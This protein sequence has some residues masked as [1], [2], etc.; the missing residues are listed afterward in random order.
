MMKAGSNLPFKTVEIK[1]VQL[2]TSVN[3]PWLGVSVTPASMG[4][5]TGVQTLVIQFSL[6]PRY[7]LSSSSHCSRYDSEG[8]YL[9]SLP[10]LA[11]PRT[12]HGCTSFVSKQGEQVKLIF[13]LYLKNRACLLL[14]V[15]AASSS[16]CP[17]LS[18]SS[19]QTEDG[20]QE[21]TF[22]GENYFQISALCVLQ[23]RVNFPQ[24][25]GRS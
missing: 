22:Q 7:D 24:R 16:T 21:E 1:P 2:P 23:C 10:D 6:W 9:G 11:T 14:E 17:A 15:Q 8:K 12:N 4:R 5:W 25:Y 13:L 20:Q 19:R 3:S 18:C